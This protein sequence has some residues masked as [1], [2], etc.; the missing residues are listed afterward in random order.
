MTVL[1]SSAG[2]RVTPAEHRSDASRT[3]LEEPSE[4]PSSR[5]E[6]VL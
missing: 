3:G 2:V 5:E 1:G 6:H 4:A